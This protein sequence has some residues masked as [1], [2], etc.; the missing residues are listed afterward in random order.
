MNTAFVADSTLGLSPSEAQARGI[1][2]V[3]AQIILDGWDY[4]DYL[5]I[6]PEQI[7]QALRRGGKLTT[8]HTS[9]AEFQR[10]Y[11][12][13]LQKYDRVVSVHASSKL[14]G[15]VSTARMVAQQFGQRVQVLDSLSVNAGLGYVLEEAQ[16]KLAEGVSWEH[17]EEAIAPLRARVQS[18]VLPQTLEY[19]W[20][21]GRI[22][23]LQFFIG[24][25]LKL[26]PILEF[27]DGL[28]KPVARVRSFH[29]GLE[30]L[31]Q[32]FRQ[33]FPAGARV[34]LA[35]AENPAALNQLESL[36]RAEGVLLEDNRPA[37]A[38][39]TVHAGPGAVALFAVPPYRPGLP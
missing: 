37:G 5:E 34:T 25:F 6:T 39:V 17:L 10:T 38:A 22:S 33:A 8:S 3:L 35:H 27:Q 23:G 32:R 28:V 21:G 7:I 20:R 9:P 4:H 24:S 31:A 19:L 13:L 2:L 26:L 30:Q 14:S 11:E 16:R 18:L 36:I 29:Q 1:H 12:M 15:F